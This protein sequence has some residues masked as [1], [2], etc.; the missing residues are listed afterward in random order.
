MSHE[1][2]SAGRIGESG[3]R[4]KPVQADLGQKRMEVGG[5]GGSGVGGT[6]GMV[7]SEYRKVKYFTGNGRIWGLNGCFGGSNGKGRE[8]KLER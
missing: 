1:W 4:R 7:A 8:L 6:W 3:A 5:A 2:S